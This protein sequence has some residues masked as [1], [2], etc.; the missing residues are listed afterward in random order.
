MI[1]FKQKQIEKG[2]QQ[3]QQQKSNQIKAQ[4]FFFLFVKLINKQNSR[5]YY[6]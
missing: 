4:Q 1:Y 2:T 3:N 6:L 5:I